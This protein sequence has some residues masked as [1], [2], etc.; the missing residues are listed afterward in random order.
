M[1]KTATGIACSMTLVSAFAQVYQCPDKASGQISFTDTPCAGGR[2]IIKELTPEEQAIRAER[3]ALARERLQLERDR[4]AVREQ[5]QAPPQSPPPVSP[6]AGKPIDPYACRTA[7]RELS[8][9]SNLQSESETGKRR[10]MN[11]AII[12]VNLACGTNTELIQEPSMHRVGSR[13]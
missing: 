4:A 11:A 3:A 2:Q 12:E 1:L 10:R 7:K 13:H 8:I 5:Q 9:A 6:P